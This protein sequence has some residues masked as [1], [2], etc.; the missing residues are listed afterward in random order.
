M[1][2]SPSSAAQ[3]ARRS[4]A[5][6]LRELRAEAGI[7]GSELGN[8]CGW[9]HSKSSRIENAITPPTPD[10]VRRWCDACGAVGQAADIIAQSQNAQ[11]LYTEW[12]RR[13]RSGLKQLQHSYV[14]LFRSTRLFRVYSATLLPHFIQTEGY[15]AG[16][17]GAISEF[18][19]IPN[20]V[21]EAVAARMERNRIVREPGRRYVLLVEEAALRHQLADAEAMAAQLGYLMTVG[22]MP[23]VSLGIIPMASRARSQWP[24]ETFHMYDDTLVSIELLSARVTVTQPS[25]IALYLKA[26]EQLRGMAVYGAEARALVV[27]AIEALG[28]A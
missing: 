26:F 10:D 4:V 20:D 9:T 13:S 25:E 24:L 19:E 7:S 27:S 8:R 21:A 12:R 2:V 15:A 6:R 28:P 3:A 23:T 16:L 17:L 22:A 11:S 18:R 1:P 5:D 14:P